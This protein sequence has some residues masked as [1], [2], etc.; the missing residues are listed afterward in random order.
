MAH[1]DFLIVGAGSAGCVLADRLSASGRHSVLLVEAGPADRHPAIRIPAAFPTLFDGRL[2]WGYRTEPEAGLGGRRVFWPRGKVLGG[3]SAINAMMWVRGFPGDYDAWRAF[4]GEGFDHRGLEGYLR[5]AERVAPEVPGPFG[6]DGALPV[7]EQLD[8]NPLTLAF[9]E[10]AARAGVGRNLARNDGP[11]EGVALTLVNQLRGERWSAARAYLSRARG[12]QNL[13]VRTGCT[14]DRLV[15]GHGRVTGVELRLRGAISRVEA[16][17]TVLAAGAIGTPRILLSSGIGPAAELEALGIEVV[18][19]S[20]RVGKNLAD[21]L[22]AGI[23][24]HARRPVSLTGARRPAAIARYARSRRGLLSSNVCE[25]YGYLRSDPALAECDLELLFAPAAFVEEGLRLPTEHGFTLGC[26]LL[27]P[28][29]RGEVRL[30]SRDPRVPPVIEARYLS[31]PEGSDESRLLAGL[32][33]CVE[34]AKSSPLVEEQDGLI[35]PHPESSRR[36]ALGDLDD[37][38]LLATLRG[39]AQTLYHPVGTCSVG[40]DD[41]A[42]TDPSLALRGL[43]G[44]FCCDASVIPVIPRGHTHAPVVAIAERQAELLAAR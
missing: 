37:D 19:H 14:V 34:I 26:V 11:E 7:G 3:S 36:V 6:R 9:L 38:R 4:G 2:D 1:Y 32:R 25:A 44:I 41:E 16:T 23:V 22:T 30:A 5:R 20:P 39:Y 12:R 21:H 8:P 28:E 24:L 33:R 27:Q 43:E 31:D 35:V 10:A 17:T 40:L 13:E 18:C 15:V 42:V 29:S